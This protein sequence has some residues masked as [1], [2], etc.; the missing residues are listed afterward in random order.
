MKLMK[1]ILKKWILHAK[2]D[3]DAAQRLFNSPKPTQWTYLLTLWHCHQTIEKMLKMVMI[4]KGKELL[5]IHDLPR[6]SKL[7]ESTLSEEDKQFL[8]DL[9]EFYLRPRYPDLLYKPLPKPERKFTKNYL[10]K[11]EKFFL[12]LQKQ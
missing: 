8:E 12:W 9:N 1:D 3:L 5:K 6:L 7:A 10:D 11:T 2:A 4:K